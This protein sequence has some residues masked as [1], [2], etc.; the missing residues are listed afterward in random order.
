MKHT[1]LYGVWNSIKNRCY[2][3]NRKDFIH[4]GGRG[5]VVCDEWKH[6]FKAF[7]DW[8]MVNGYNSDAPRGECTIDRIDVN[9]NYCPENC[10]W[11]SMKEQS[12]NKRTVG[13][14]LEGGAGNGIL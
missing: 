7:Y 1:R 2:N 3:Q 4:Y 5:I 12:Q 11:V 8:A 13:F 6:D 10:R 9:G 14:D